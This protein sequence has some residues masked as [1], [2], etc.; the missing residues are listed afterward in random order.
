MGERKEIS[1]RD[2]N[3]LADAFGYEV[4]PSLFVGDMDRDGDVDFDD[5]DDF[6]LALNNP[7]LYKSTYCV[8]GALP[9]DTDGDADHDFDDITGFVDILVS[10]SPGPQVS[11][12]PE[13]STLLLVCVALLGASRV[14]PRQ[15]ARQEYV[16]DCPVCCRANV[17]HVEIDED[18]NATVLAEPEQDFE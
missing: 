14:R 4:K 5:I 16:G 15:R 10:G 17:I 18:G 8:P 7:A 9:V 3:I 1:S 13:P 6:V 11:S 2:L 12:V